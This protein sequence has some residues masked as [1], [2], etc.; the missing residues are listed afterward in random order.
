MQQYLGLIWL[1]HVLYPQYCDYDVKA[2][3]LEF[4]RLVYHCE[5]TD[6]QY[7]TLTRG[8]FLNP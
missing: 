4:Y 6:A 5:L 7:E 8:A 1:T 3:I 2:D